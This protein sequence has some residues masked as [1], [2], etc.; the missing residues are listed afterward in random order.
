VHGQSVVHA[1]IKGAN[2]LVTREGSAIL[3]DFGIAWTCVKNSVSFSLDRDSKGTVRWMAPELFR[4]S[5]ATSDDD[6]DAP[7]YTPASDIWSYGCLFLEVSAFRVDVCASSYNNE[8]VGSKPV[9]PLWLI[10]RSSCHHCV[11]PEKTPSSA[12]EYA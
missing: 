2:V 6:A 1:D 12:S 8:D 3:C 9:S 10:A 5:G 7:L 4:F 11:V